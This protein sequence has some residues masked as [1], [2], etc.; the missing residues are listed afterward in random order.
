MNESTGI[1]LKIIV[2]RAVRPVRASTSRKRKM[3]EELLAHVRGVFDEEWARLGDDRAAVERTALRFGNPA[4]VTGQLQESVPASDG[5]LRVLEGRPGESMLRGVLRFAWL[6]GLIAWAALGAALFVAGWVSAWSREELIAVVSSFGFLPMWLC[7]PLWLLA[8]TLVTYWLE[9]SL[10]GPEPL[11][12]WP[13]IG[14]VKVLTSAWAVPAVR[15]ALIV[16][17]LCLLALVGIGG[18]Q[19]P[20]YRAHWNHLDVLGAFFLV[21]I[22]MA[23]S[24][25]CAWALVQTVDEGRRCH[26]EWSR[27]PI[28]PHS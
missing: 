16:G 11:I 15:I 2:E 21:G 1:Q 6:E 4:E 18:F 17:G 19:W 14:L 24:V 25:V 10:H 26:E 13:R 8:V 9:K 28:E 3:R 7:M 22:M 27:L 23:L 12:G 5:I 20:M